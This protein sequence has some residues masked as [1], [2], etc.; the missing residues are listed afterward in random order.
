MFWYLAY[1][2]AFLAGSIPF[3][4]II[5]RANGVNIREVGSGNIG[6]TNVGR[7]VGLRPGILC[8]VLDVLKGLVPIAATGAAAGLLGTFDVPTDQAWLWLGIMI[9]TVAGHMFSPWVNFK[10]GKGVATGMGSLLGVFPA[11]TGPALAI[12]ILWFV[13]L[14]RWKMVGIASA[15]AVSMLPVFVVIQFAIVGRLDA[16]TPFIVVTGLLALLIVVRH[17]G[18]IAR[19]FAGTEPRLG[20]Q[21]GPGLDRE[22]HDAAKAQ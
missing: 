3:G 5:A 9:A 19:T 21:T 8:L 16:G 14:K 2:G 22:R 7:T 15:I 4:L 10:G 13:I 6:A 18:N 17:R 11:L 20:E 1:A 12:L